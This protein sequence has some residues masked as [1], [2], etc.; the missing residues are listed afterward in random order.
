MEIPEVAESAREVVID[1]PQR[2]A[3]AL[4]AVFQVDAGGILDVVPRRLDQ[5]RHLPQLGVHPAGALGE[6]GVVEQDLPGETGGQDLGVVLEALLPGPYLFELEQPRSDV[7]L[8]GGP[9]EPFS[10]GQPG[11]VNGRQPAGEP[12]ERPDLAVNRLAAEVLDEIV[13]Q[14]DTVERCGR[15]V[16]FVEVRQILVD[17]VRKGF[18]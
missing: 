3:K 1:E 17:E 7:G 12:A 18:G 9:L 5:P 16:D 2:A 11:G 13:V 6:R 15:G 14:V 4:Q 8:Q 10:V